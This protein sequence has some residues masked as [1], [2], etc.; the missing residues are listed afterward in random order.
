MPAVKMSALRRRSGAH[1][2]ETNNGR[3]LVRFPCFVN[4]YKPQEKPTCSTVVV[5][6]DHAG[7]KETRRN[8]R[9]STEMRLT[10]KF[11]LAE[12]GNEVGLPQQLERLQNADAYEGKK[13]VHVSYLWLQKCVSNKELQVKKIPAGASET[14]LLTKLVPESTAHRLLAA[15]EHEYRNQWRSAQAVKSA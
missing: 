5:D 15:S 4:I 14:D 10:R 6:S 12:L 2:A 9:S 7:D 1:D 8:T 11:K 3:P 13:H